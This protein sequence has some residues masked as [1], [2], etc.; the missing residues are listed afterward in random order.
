M[1]DVPAGPRKV[2]DTRFDLEVREKVEVVEEVE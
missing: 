1:T 2:W